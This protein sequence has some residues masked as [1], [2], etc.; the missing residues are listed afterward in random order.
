MRV[1]AYFRLGEVR[2]SDLRAALGGDLLKLNAVDVL[3]I[4][5]PGCMA[6]TARVRLGWKRAGRGAHRALICPRCLEPKLRLYADG[7]GGLGCRLCL[8][9]RSRQQREKNRLSF[10]HLGGR[11]DDILLRLLRRPGQSTP[12]ALAK[13]ALLVQQLVG[14]DRDRLAALKMK[15]ASLEQS[16]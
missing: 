16:R 11:E 7:A 6:S 15:L 12:G 10:Q 4:G 2:I 3:V 14:A 9:R 13:G 5:M 8:K 1:E